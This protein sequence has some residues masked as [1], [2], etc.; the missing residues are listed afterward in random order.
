[1]LTPTP[2]QPPTPPPH[3]RSV[4]T[5][6]HRLSVGAWISQDKVRKANIHQPGRHTMHGDNTPKCASHPL[7]CGWEVMP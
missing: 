5:V 4:G 1:M 3:P 6:G 2:P 7:G